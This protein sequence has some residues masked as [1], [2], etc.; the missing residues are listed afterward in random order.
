M[1]RVVGFA[2]SLRKGSYNRSLLAA[3][4][5]AMP[6]G[7]SLAALPIDDVP[8]YNADIEENEGIPLSVQF[9]QDEIAAADGL[10]I[11]TP[12]YN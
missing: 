10:V 9:L 8:L 12:E 11:A 1:I 7:A 2:G 3:A 4:I 6:D 5:D